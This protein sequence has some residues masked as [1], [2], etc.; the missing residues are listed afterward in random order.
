[1]ISESRPR[2]IDEAKTRKCAQDLRRCVY[3]ETCATYGHNVDRVFQEACH[4]IVT[5]QQLGRSLRLLRHLDSS[6]NSQGG[7][8]MNAR[9][10]LYNVP[11]PGKD[12]LPDSLKAVM[13]SLR[14]FME[15]AQALQPV[16]LANRKTITCDEKICKG[17]QRRRATVITPVGS[18]ISQ[19]RSARVTLIVA[20]ANRRRRVVA[21][22]NRVR[23]PEASEVLLITVTLATE[24]PISFNSASSYAAAA[25]QQQQQQQQHGKPDKA[26]EQQL[27]AGFQHADYSAYYASASVPSIAPGSCQLSLPPPPPLPPHHQPQPQQQQLGQ[28][29]AKDRSSFAQG[30]PVQEGGERSQTGNGRKKYVTLSEDGKLTYHPNLHDYMENSHGKDIDL[31]RTTVKIP[32]QLRPTSNGLLKS[33]QQQQQQQPEDGNKKRRHRRAKSGNRGGGGGG[34][35]QDVEESDGY[36]FMIVSLENRTCTL[37]LPVKG[38]VMNGLIHEKSQSIP[39]CRGFAPPGRAIEHSIL[40]SLQGPSAYGNYGT[41]GGSSNC[42][43]GARRQ[44]RRRQRRRQLRQRLNPW[45]V[46]QLGVRGLRRPGP[47]TGQPE[48]GRWCA[49]SAAGCTAQL[50]THLSRIRS[51]TAGRLAG[52]SPAGDGRAI[53]NKLA[54]S[55]WEARL[56]CHATFR[57]PSPESD[58]EAKEI[59]IRAKYERRVLPRI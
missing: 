3:L 5:S 12:A 36:E 40:R 17:P 24:S 13:M 41:S 6:S 11:P 14:P 9:G 45:R 38:A 55:V 51:L 31:S 26:E 50:G 37:R 42:L 19:A 48:P 30:S 32:G 34:A 21:M 46:R 56:P 58:R 29:V 10:G 57:K 47:W 28:R 22:E 44:R 53:G 16:K 4:R 35:D 27:A 39:C 7:S 25:R 52:K 43:A 18:D 23:A 8:H 59:F 20:A 1:S 49:S 33:Q 54:N 15:S 2:V